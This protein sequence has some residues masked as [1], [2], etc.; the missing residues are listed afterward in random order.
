MAGRKGAETKIGT[1][2]PATRRRRPFRAR[3]R[4]EPARRVTRASYI[5]R[6]DFVEPRI[7]TRR[8]WR[9]ARAVYYAAGLRAGATWCQH[10]SVISGRRAAHLSMHPP[11]RW[12]AL[13][14]RRRSQATRTQVRR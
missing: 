9:G 4:R 3:I 13:S 11:A 10:L 12:V 2:C 8:S 7:D 14:F 6:P 1:P 5:A